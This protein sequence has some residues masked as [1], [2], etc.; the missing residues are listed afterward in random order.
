MRL[1]R[2]LAEL[3]KQINDSEASAEKRRNRDRHGASGASQIALVKRELEQMLDYKRRELRSL[4]EG[5]G[6]IEAGKSLKAVRD[7]LD[8]VKEQ[9]DGLEQHLRRREAV[10][11]EVLDEAAQEK[12]TRR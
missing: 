5:S 12:A 11:R 2:E 1:K 6:S 8:M 9:V 3:E 4:E 10:L 7:D